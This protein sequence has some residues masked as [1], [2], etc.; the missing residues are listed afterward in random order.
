MQGQARSLRELVQERGDEVRAE[1]TDP[2][3]GEV[4]VRD[5]ER[6]AGCLE[7]YVGE[8]FVGGHDRGRVMPGALG[9]QRFVELLAE[10]STRRGHL[11][12]DASGLHL[13]RQIEVG[14]LREQ[15]E[16]VVEDGQPGR[17]VGRP[18]AVHDDTD[19]ASAGGRHQPSTRSIR[20]PS[21][22]R[23]SSMRS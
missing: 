11:G 19:G 12:V 13:E 18:L 21:E 14:V 23:R 22:R 15:T 3:L 2:R 6:T 5:D 8:R 17:D 7:R 1:A 4:D 9:A 16:Q 20:A 10:G